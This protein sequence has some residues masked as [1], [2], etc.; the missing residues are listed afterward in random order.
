MFRVLGIYNFAWGEKI[1]AR[2]KI[3]VNCAY[4]LLLAKGQLIS[5]GLFAIFTWTKKRTKNFSISALEIYST[6]VGSSPTQG[7]IF[8][9][10]ICV[11][12]CLVIYLIQINRK[13]YNN[14]WK[15]NYLRSDFSK[16]KKILPSVRLEPTKVSF[17]RAEIE[18]FFVRFWVQV[19]IAKSP[20]EINWPLAQSKINQIE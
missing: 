14:N 17:F 12:K 18:K 15:K 6:F 5:K 1:S 16:K 11:L 19:K 8:F 3:T 10:S 20:F 7:H 9:S 4:L 13:M 2:K